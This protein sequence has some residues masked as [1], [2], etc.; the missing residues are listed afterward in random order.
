MH[1]QLGAGN[2]QGIAHVITGIAHIYKTDPLQMSE[3]LMDGKHICQHLGRM[4]LVGQ[5]VPYR[6]S[7]IF[8]QFFHNILAESTVFNTIIHPA[9]NSCCICNTLFLAD[10]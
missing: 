5:A 1:T 2:H 6:D 4:I 3:M 7:C 8:C 10:L 9:K